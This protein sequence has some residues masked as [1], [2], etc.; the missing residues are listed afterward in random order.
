MSFFL[1]LF[2]FPSPIPIY[3]SNLKYPTLL[4][5]YSNEGREGTETITYTSWAFNSVIY[6]RESLA[7]SQAV[8]VI[9]RPLLPTGIF[10]L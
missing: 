4:R 6:K 3:S 10:N 9:L 7:I 1:D 8:V 5:T 2:S